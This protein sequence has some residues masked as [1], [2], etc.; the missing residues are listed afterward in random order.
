MNPLHAW[1]E[2]I[3]E[4]VRQTLASRYGWP[5]VTY[6][7]QFHPEHMRF[8]DAAA[9]V[10]YLHALGISH[11]YASPLL[12]A[13]A[14]SPHGYDVVD[15]G[16]LNPALGSEDDYA[17]MIDAIHGHGMGL[18]QDIVPN[19]MGIIAAE[20]AWWN[21]V[22]ENGPGSP[23]ARCF[24]ID[25]HPVTPVLEN[26]VLLPFLGGQ[27]GEIL[28]SGQLRIEYREGAFFVRYGPRC[29]P[30]DPRTYPSILGHEQIH[31]QESLGADSD[32]FREY[33][34]ILTALEYLP[35]ATEDNPDRI[36]ERQREKE[37]V[38]SRLRRLSA[39]VPAVADFIEHRLRE[40]NG[41]PSD[42]RSFDR[43]D[44]LLKA[45]VYRL[46][47]WKAAS[48]EVNYR[49]FFDINELAAVCTE[50]P[51]VFDMIHQLVFSLLVRGD[52]D[53]LRID[54]IDGLYDPLEYLWRLQW[55][56]VKAL[57]RAAYERC[58]PGPSAVE[59]SGNAAGEA[60]P[61]S[62]E[63]LEPLVLQTLRRELGALPPPALLPVYVVVEK[64]LGPDEPL[65][66]EWPVAGT[67]GYD[68][69]NLVNRLFVDRAGLANM[70]RI[71][72]RFTNERTDFR[73]VCYQSRLLILRV[74]MSSELQ[75]LAHRINR[76]SERHRRSRDFT[77][78]SLRI[79]LREIL[80]CFPVYRTY[81]H[82]GRFSDRDRQVVLRAVAQAKRRNPARDPAV[83]DFIRD[84][85]LLQQPPE[86]DDAGRAEREL[87]VGRFQQ[88]TSPLVAKGIEDTAFYQ[89]VPLVS[90]NEVGGDPDKG[91]STIGD[92]HH[93]NLDRLATRHG[94]LV[95]GTT[96]DTKR[97]EDV[98]ARINVLS[99]VPQR[100][101]SAVNRWSRLNRRHRREV[102][103]LPAPSR[104]DEYLLYQT[105]VGVWPPELL[106]PGSVDGAFVERLQNYMS[107]ATH[108]AKRRT[109]W[110]SPN[111]DYDAAVQDFV[112]AILA[113]HPKNRFLDHLR[114]FVDSLLD[115]GLY[116][117][118]SQTLLKLTSPG[119]P[120][121]YQGQEVW[122]FLLVDPD[123]RR[124][125]DFARRREL[126]AEIQSQ[127]SGDQDAFLAFA[128]HVATHPRDPRLKLLVTW[129]TL[130]F[131]RRHANLFHHGQYY[132][133]SVEGT[134]AEHVCAFAWRAAPLSNGPEQIAMVIVPRLMA[135]L[136]SLAPAAPVGGEA[137]GPQRPFGEAF[138]A[139][140]WLSFADLAPQRLKNL[141]TGQN[142]E[143]R[144]QGVRIA[145]ALAEF[146][147]AVLANLD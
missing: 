111:A 37:V 73:E 135:R 133:L 5:E 71:Y 63:E 96:H 142:C 30:I 24:D 41:D 42:A 97:S 9:M 129:Q 43:L 57:G 4:D 107:K 36:A 101:R 7:L 87:F 60:S 54:H 103:G 76:I 118:L 39:E 61:P 72:Q 45:Q 147:V 86:L 140:T 23:Y 46:A 141:F 123:N 12:K 52:I 47:H 90:L 91:A 40:L 21:D 108:E 34:S 25:W 113:D 70:A 89:Y 127:V 110:I 132:P 66:E 105:L 92:F 29:L 95:T 121:I 31:L 1:V 128:R 32:A 122:E 136:A 125:V 100:W 114:A 115:W 6:R 94:S 144:N 106:A 59:A 64:I 18:L 138:W 58:C 28:E 13:A 126:L 3:A 14:N 134:A 109:S 120:D 26:K 146:P 104:N 56:Y 83:F 44:D 15:Y 131:R 124:P 8:R 62:W 17:A 19:H 22:L 16:K 10:P 49:R 53:G 119:V 85:L 102:D 65:P 93:D 112:A 88:V 82:E 48:E 81:I 79:A 130:Q 84:V 98:R 145:D 80:A 75:L 20:N 143:I 74:A 77:L 117:A 67:T 69:L 38:K 55:G 99:E 11:I 50:A 137:N 68:F 139:D 2:K 33:A 27:Y 51:S 116:G 35:A 78:N